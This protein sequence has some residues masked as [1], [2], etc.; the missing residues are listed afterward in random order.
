M[1][2]IIC[3]AG[4]GNRLG[5]N[6][7]K[8]L[9]QVAGKPIIQWQLEILQQFTQDI[10][11]V[12][13]FKSDIVIEF[14]N[15]FNVKHVVN[16]HYATTSVVDS[17]LLGIGNQ[18]SEVLLVDGDVLFTSEGIERVIKAVGD[19]VC[20]KETISDDSPVFVEVENNQIKKFYREKSGYLEWAGICKINSDYMNGSNKYI[21]QG[22]ERQ[23]PLPCLIIDSV[24][25]DTSKDL[26]DA[27]KWIMKK[28]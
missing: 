9:A 3:A 2:T 17:I 11:I 16:P 1:K 6:I 7:P 25:I 24:E 12:V 22:L 14:I 20:I 28:K 8:C 21:Y 27:E 23:L 4:L 13:G 18:Q 19:V 15:K 26:K 5:L 10:T